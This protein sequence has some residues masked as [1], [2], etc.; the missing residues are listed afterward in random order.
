MSRREVCAEARRGKLK[1][2]KERSDGVA[3]EAVAI[4][5]QCV[6]ISRV[7]SKLRKFSKKGGKSALM[8]KLAA[9]RCSLFDGKKRYKISAELICEIALDLSGNTASQATAHHVSKRSVERCGDAYGAV[10]MLAQ[11]VTLLAKEDELRS[12]PP[13]WTACSPQWDETGEKVK[14]YISK[15][16]RLVTATLHMFVY[17]M[18]FSW[19]YATG[20]MGTIR[21]VLPPIPISATTAEHLWD[22]MRTH[23]WSKPLHRFKLFL[24][25]IATLPFQF[26]TSDQASGNV[27]LLAYEMLKRPLLLLL[28]LPCFNHQCFLG[29]LDMVVAVFRA[30][31]LSSMYSTARFFN[32]G[33]HRLRCCM[34]VATFLEKAVEFVIGYPSC[35]DGLFAE[36][37]LAYVRQWDSKAT[38][39]KTGLKTGAKRWQVLELYFSIVGGGYCDRKGK[40]LVFSKGHAMTAEWKRD[41]LTR[42][43]P[44]IVDLHF[45][46]LF[47]LPSSGKW[48]KTGPCSER[49]A[50]GTLNRILEQV[51]SLALGDLQ[52]ST[53][54]GDL[55]FD[56]SFMEWS[57]IASKSS[58]IASE[59]VADVWCC[60]QIMLLLVCDEVYR[61]LTLVHMTLSSDTDPAFDP[62]Q[63]SPIQVLSNDAR[64]PIY[65]SLCHLSSLLAGMSSRLRLV[66][67]FRGCASFG[68]W[69]KTYPGDAEILFQACS[70]AAANIHRRQRSH[71][72]KLDVQILAMGDP[73]MP[74]PIAVDIADRVARSTV[75][76]LP[77]G[78]GQR[79]WQYH[80]DKVPQ[81]TA[82]RTSVIAANIVDDRKLVG[83]ASWSVVASV[84]PCENLHKYH[85]SFAKNGDQVRTLSSVANNSIASQFSRRHCKLVGKY[86]ECEAAPIDA[87]RLSPDWKPEY[88][89]ALA[90]WEVHR[91]KWIASKCEEDPSFNCCTT[92]AWESWRIAWRSAS[93]E[94]QAKC[95]DD[96]AATMVIAAAE[97]SNLLAKMSEGNVTTADKNV[98]GEMATK[99][100]GLI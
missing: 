53:A 69:V 92:L 34:V 5:E 19:G 30:T 39:A 83:R 28:V 36:E 1:K 2:A 70:T 13:Y 72:S 43:G 15:M 16:N 51:M 38:D 71:L 26:A 98:Y 89:R 60:V 87:N 41:T 23:P 45:L 85:R 76:E 79:F 18:I 80:Q 81:S 35:A 93:I 31:F 66:W 54:A 37:L 9:L 46:N 22:A 74:A 48:T 6:T 84:F 67:H 3:A 68:E 63:P 7:G 4:A 78:L 49:F 12:K 88:Q 58:K 62:V 56:D 52:F 64:S 95:Q 96:S 32:M 20:E 21:C 40:L 94:D 77:A 61:F 25:G 29:H 57:R 27:K 65:S 55:D 8:K 10:A 44:I 17:V 11:E 90:P 59:F 24:E 97:A 75:L 86:T 99:V 100:Q 33:A 82:N 47:P 73:A 50:L 91:K 14:V 42:L